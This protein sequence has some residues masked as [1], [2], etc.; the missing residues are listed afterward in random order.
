MFERLKRALSGSDS[1]P[2][3]SPVPAAPEEPGRLDW[4]TD[5][6]PYR[7]RTWLVDPAQRDQVPAILDGLLRRELSVE[8]VDEPD[9]R[10]RLDMVSTFDGWAAVTRVLSTLR[11]SGVRARGLERLD[12]FDDVSP[13]EL[14]RLVGDWETRAHDTSARRR[15]DAVAGETTIRYAIDAQRRHPKVRGWRFLVSSAG[16]RTPGAAALLLATAVAEP[17]ADIA[18]VYGGAVAAQAEVAKLVSEPIEPPA[19]LVLALARRRDRAAEAAFRLAG[20]LRAP[21]D[22]ELTGVLCVAVR[23]RRRDEIG[24]DALRALRNARPTGEVRAAMATAL[25]STDADVRDAAL[26]ALGAVFGVGA[27]PYWQAW[28]ASSSWPQ[29]MAAEDVIGQFGDADDVPL[30]AEHLG[31][32]IRRRSSTSWE[33]PR[34]SEIIN[35][36]VRHREVPEARAGLADLMQRWPKLPEELRT[37]LTRHYPDLVP[38]EAPGPGVD[39]EP[40]D[41]VGAEPPLTWPLPEIKREGSALYLGYWDTDMF[42]V[43]ERFEE[44]LDEHPAVTL[45]DGDREWQ[46]LRIDSPDPEALIGE[47]WARAHEATET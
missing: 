30:A 37:W 11:R 18:V 24:T 20:A 35:L 40:A 39:I 32:I 3:P 42:A 23:D 5:Q 43:R 2:P 1:P 19:D 44:L 15:M 28:L 47:L 34:G 33:P 29:R 8:F 13:D 27:R 25:E 31:K 46:T 36:L 12:L 10:L 4:I 26:G 22:D 45:L 38:E 7:F 17:D 14:D 16:Q 41:D 21:L 6:T 9:G